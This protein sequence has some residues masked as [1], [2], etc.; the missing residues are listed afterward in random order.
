MAKEINL[1]LLNDAKTQ[2][3]FWSKVD[4]SAGDSGCWV[5]VG[6]AFDDGYGAF[7]AGG[8]TYRAHRASFAMTNNSDPGDLVVRHSCHNPL[9]VNPSHLSAGTVEDNTADMVKAGRGKSCMF[10]ANDVIDIRESYKK[11]ES[12]HSIADRYSVREVNIDHLISGKT[13]WHVREGL[14]PSIPKPVK[15]KN[16]TN[17]KSTNGFHHRLSGQDQPNA[18]LSNDEIVDIRQM[19]R[20]GVSS[21]E[22]CQLAGISH[23]SFSS[24]VRGK[25]Y[26]NA[27]GPIFSVMRGNKHK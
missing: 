13:Y 16:G 9:C 15:K 27:G 22:I 4:K 10:D 3:R 20:D 24:I 6:V 21:S 19:Y 8:K 26:K 2:E 12:I 17:P 18:K 23:T 7:K 11:G 14:D 1:S 5:W 25:S